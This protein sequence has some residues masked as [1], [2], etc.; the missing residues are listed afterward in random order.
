MTLNMVMNG[1][2]FQDFL[3]NPLNFGEPKITNGEKS[4]YK[5]GRGADGRIQI[6]GAL[7]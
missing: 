3:K 6:P 2:P 1:F 4:C 5:C 7:Y